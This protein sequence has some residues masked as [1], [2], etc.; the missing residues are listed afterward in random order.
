MMGKIKTLVKKH[1]ALTALVAFAVV[2]PI[3]DLLGLPKIMIELG[4]I[5]CTITLG[6]AVYAGAWVAAKRPEW[7]EKA[8]TYLYQKFKLEK[9][10]GELEVKDELQK[11][12]DA[13]EAKRRAASKSLA[14]EEVSEDWVNNLYNQFSLMFE[15]YEKDYIQIDSFELAGMVAY[16]MTTGLDTRKQLAVVY[17]CIKDMLIKPFT[18]DIMRE[19]E[20]GYYEFFGLDHVKPLESLKMELENDAQFKKEV[21][22]YLAMYTADP[23]DNRRLDALIEVLRENTE[24]SCAF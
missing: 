16:S 7:F 19:F 6:L 8:S 20:D 15:R 18:C 10:F 24:C 17:E 23:K 22:D 13:I 21:I 9:Y 3:M 11:L 5:H 1:P 4:A 12:F 2:Y 14:D